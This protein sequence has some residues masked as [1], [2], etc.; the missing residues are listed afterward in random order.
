VVFTGCA[1]VAVPPVRRRRPAA[2]KLHVQRHVRLPEPQRE[3]AVCGDERQRG[4]SEVLPQDEL[5]QVAEALSPWT[6]P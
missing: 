4:V 5:G 3:R 2:I 6:R 1:I